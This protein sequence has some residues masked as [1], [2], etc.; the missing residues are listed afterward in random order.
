MANKWKEVTPVRVALTIAFLI[1]IA[2][3]IKY[4]GAF[5]S[6]EK[7]EDPVEVW[8]PTAVPDATFAKLDG[9]S[10]RL[11]AFTG[12]IVL[13][14]FWASWCAPCIQEFP[15][16]LKLVE[17]FPDQLVLVAVSNDSKRAGIDKFLRRFKKLLNSDVLKRNVHIVWDKDLKVTQDRF[18]VLRLP[19]T[20]V[21]NKSSRIAR[22]VIGVV[23]WAGIEMRSYVETLLKQ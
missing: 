16:M 13:L 12:K 5:S 8:E 4:S 18:N 6:V 9:G 19:E 3:G 20:F 23:D 22:K 7:V 2:F 11:D 15:D 21:L 1:P 14:N 17:H 10:L